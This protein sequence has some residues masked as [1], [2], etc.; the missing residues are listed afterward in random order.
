ME[1]APDTARDFVVRTMTADEVN[2]AIEWA[3]REGWNPGLHDASC[4]RCAD[5]N[6]FFIGEWRGEPVGSISA[7]AYD[8]HFG[9][10]GLYIVRPEFRGKG[11]GLRIWQHG[12][13]YLGTRNIGLDGVVA[14]QPNYRKSGFELAYRN[15]RFQGIA[16]ADPSRDEA[17]LV[18]VHGL[19]FEQF[20]SYDGRFFPAP[21]AAFLRAWID[22][23]DSVALAYIGD[24]RIRG[25]GVLRRCRE[26]RKIGPLFADDK[27]IAEALFAALVARC[28][29]EVVA[30]DVPELN[31]AAVAL[32]ERHRLTSV[33]ETARMYTKHAPDLPLTR[34][35]GVTTFELG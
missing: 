25:Y 24:G 34:L 31:P 27:R 2:L 12:I 18:D 17:A 16:E 26:G 23:P 4:F 32:A 11:F 8:G 33:F 14:Q 28:P 35:Y 15:I 19:P 21:R 20:A 5:P 30:L 6:G 1:Q 3:A 29:N 13:D 9:F 22:Q 7:I 10:I